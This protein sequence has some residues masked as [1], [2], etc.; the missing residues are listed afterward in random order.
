MSVKLLRLLDNEAEGERMAMRLSLAESHAR[1]E[2]LHRALESN[3]EEIALALRQ[4]F[5]RA[6]ENRQ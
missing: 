3:T 5:E 2:D 6:E 4:A 1:A